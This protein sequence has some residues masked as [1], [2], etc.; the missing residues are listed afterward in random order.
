MNNLT[1]V[2]RGIS[3]FRKKYLF[4]AEFGRTLQ[5]ITAIIHIIFNDHK[6]SGPSIYIPFT[7]WHL[8]AA[9]EFFTH[10]KLLNN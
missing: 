6:Q 7:R 3:P 9:W 4:T 8:S 1:K 2:L 10:S 5:L